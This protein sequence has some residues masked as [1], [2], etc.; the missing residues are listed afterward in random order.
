MRACKCSPNIC[1][2]RLDFITFVISGPSTLTGSIGETI[3][4]TFT[5]VAAGG[6]GSDVTD[7]GQ[8]NTDTFTIGSSQVP[9]IC[10]TNTGDH[11][12]FEA[13]Q[14]CHFLDF[15]FG[16]V[17]NGISNIASRSWNIKITQ[18]S[19][20]HPNLAPV[21]CTQYYYGTEATNQVRTFNW[22]G[23][24]HLNS[25]R[26]VICVRREAGNCKICWSADTPSTDF[27][28]G[29]KAAKFNA[30]KGEICCAY[31]ADGKGPTGDHGYDCVIIPGAQKT[32]GS[33][34]N[35]SQCGHGQGLA[36]LHSN[37]DNDAKTI[38]CKFEI[39]MFSCFCCF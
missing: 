17:A 21:G 29:G 14:E 18:Y 15:Q 5:T 3:H 20:D 30:L 23:T 7:A 38:C 24:R 37:A 11:V 25:Q 8:C 10:G 35:S 39:A 27:E 33:I 31:E 34:I 13:T 9:T 16:N 26:Q 6:V 32:G 12:Y 36:T 1:Q 19:C 28:I 22:Q 4:G 2:I